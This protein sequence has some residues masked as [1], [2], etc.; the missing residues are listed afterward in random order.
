MIVFNFFKSP[1]HCLL[2]NLL[3]LIIGGV[4]ICISDQSWILF[5]GTSLTVYGLVSFVE[6][7]QI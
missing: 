3:C 2:F 5:C 4:L 1:V 7:I 6:I